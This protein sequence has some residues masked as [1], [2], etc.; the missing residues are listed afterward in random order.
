MRH[1]TRFT[2]WMAAPLAVLFFATT[3]GLG[4]AQAGLVATD[5][6][7]RENRLDADRERVM[8]FVERADV[9]RE[10]AALGVAPDEASARVA[11]MSDAE[12][13]QIAQRMDQDP[14]GEGAIGAIVGAALIVFIVLLITDVAGVTN[15]F[16]FTK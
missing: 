6:L 4:T 8:A 16:S 5:G 12:I 13:A 2:R 3:F 10:I 7:A 1:F 9:Q 11:A 14:A 15:V